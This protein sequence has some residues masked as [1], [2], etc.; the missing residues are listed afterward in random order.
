M[1]KQTIGNSTVIKRYCCGCELRRLNEVESVNALARRM[2]FVRLC[3]RDKV[4]DMGF[5][6]TEA[7]MAETVDVREGVVVPFPRAAE[8]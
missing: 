2:L 3:A 5:A 6:V 7:L 4:A 1:S 8:G